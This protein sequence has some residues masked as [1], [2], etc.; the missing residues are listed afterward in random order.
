MEQEFWTSRTKTITAF[1]GSSIGLGNM[2]NM[3][4]QIINDGGFIYLI[5]YICASAVITFSFFLGLL[6]LGRMSRGSVLSM[7]N[8]GALAWK[9]LGYLILIVA[10]LITSNYIVSVGTV[11]RYV[12]W[13][14]TGLYNAPD[15]VS[16]T[17][18]TSF[19]DYW[20]HINALNGKHLSGISYIW[21]K[22]DSFL[23][24]HS[25]TKILSYAL[26][27]IN[28]LYSTTHSMTLND[29]HHH[30]NNYISSKST[31]IFS[32]PVTYTILILI[33]CF[34]L[35][36]NKIHIVLEKFLLYS[37]IISLL[38]I[39]ILIIH[40]FIT[41]NYYQGLHEF[42]KPKALNLTSFAQ[43]IKNTIVKSFFS[44]SL[45]FGITL[46]YGSYIRKDSN[47]FKISLWVVS[48]DTLVSICMVFLI[49]PI[50]HKLNLENYNHQDALF[51]VLPML[52]AHIHN[53]ILW[54]E[55]FFIIILL[56]TLT[57]ILSCL[58][59]IISV[60]KERTALGRRFSVLLACTLM[61]LLSIHID[62]S[63]GPLSLLQIHGSHIYSFIEIIS[64]EIG[65]PLVSLLLSIYMG[66]VVRIDVFKEI[67]TIGKVITHIPFTRVW[68]ILI[69]YLIPFFCLYIL[70]G[71]I[72]NLLY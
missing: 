12:F 29:F 8:G 28:N 59:V 14:L 18:A 72:Y 5:F 34:L 26:Y 45:G 41:P 44:L 36:Q 42:L 66:W 31:S 56:V 24:F 10:L 51:I 16:F 61:G 25:V 46:T 48:V 6:G 47:L 2:W 7:F 9:C 21:D 53:G 17:S 13:T 15:T 37:V 57:S 19:Y 55:I 70:L 30:Y 23:P 60:L 69:K 43:M 22:I 54:S 20:N 40:S 63:H 62:L 64:Q 38:Y 71:N 50:I 32:I 52:F 65:I 4:S 58:E 49:L 3:P 68:K 39:V 67:T 35:L 11:L 33:A 1:L 27:R